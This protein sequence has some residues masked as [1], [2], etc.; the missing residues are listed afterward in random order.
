MMMW[1][2]ENIEQSI[3]I[4]LCG[5]EIYVARDS[6]VA[7]VFRPKFPYVV[8]NTEI[9]I[10]KVRTVETW[11]DEF[12]EYYYEADPAAKNFVPF[13]GDLSE[14]E[15]LKK[16]L[17]CKPFKWYVEKFRQVFTERH[18]LPEEVFLIRDTS[19]SL[20]LAA[21]DDSAHMATCDEGDVLQKWTVANS[22]DGLRNAG[23]RKCIDA[24]AGNPNKDGSTLF[25]Y[26][27]MPMNL[28]QKWSMSGGNIRWTNFCVKASEKN[29]DVTLTQCGSFL[30]GS[31]P[32]EKYKAKSTPL[33]A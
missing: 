18:M 11:F 8:N 33:G 31:G 17:Q 30:S 26:A 6:R 16:K 1:G 14:R 15:A 21:H 27:C 20:C 5:G 29:K 3:R 4:W 13:M 25:L 10:N 22:G 2:A 28:Q 19:T 12:K 9:Y 24:N 7:H 23:S 32:F